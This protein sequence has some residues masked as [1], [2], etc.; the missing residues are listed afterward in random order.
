M[1]VAFDTYSHIIGG[2][3]PYVGGTE[4]ASPVAILPKVAARAVEI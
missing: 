2:C 1:G 3:G 4:I